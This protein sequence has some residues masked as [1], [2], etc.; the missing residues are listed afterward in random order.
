[1]SFSVR[2]NVPLH[3]EACWCKRVC[4]HGGTD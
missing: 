3:K 1:V 4:E 2:A